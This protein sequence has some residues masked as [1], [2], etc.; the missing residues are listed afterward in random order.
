MILDIG[1][2]G[3]G[4]V[5]GPHG[6]APYRVFEPD[7][8]MARRGSEN[9]LGTVVTGEKTRAPRSL[10]V[11]LEKRPPP[12]VLTEEPRQRS[13][14]SGLRVR[15]LC[16]APSPQTTPGRA[17]SL[18]RRHLQRCHRYGKGVL[19]RRTKSTFPDVSWSYSG[20]TSFR[21]HKAPKR[22]QGVRI[23]QQKRFV[24]NRFTA[25]RGPNPAAKSFR[26]HEAPK[27]G[28]PVWPT[29]GP[30]GEAILCSQCKGCERPRRQPPSANHDSL[31]H[32]LGEGGGKGTS[33]VLESWRASA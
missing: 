10:P 33:S 17:R 13:S 29:A 21:G 7:P 22:A 5:W 9:G 12:T 1:T 26:G 15:V 23:R 3:G 24:A 25:T 8:T 16:G 19:I 28:H 4:L 27:G 18:Q 32:F 30:I 31:E 2:G 11:T 20:K 14:V 6:V